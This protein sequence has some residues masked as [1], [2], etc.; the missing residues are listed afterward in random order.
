MCY[1]KNIWRVLWYHLCCI[2]PGQT[3]EGLHIPWGAKNKAGQLLPFCNSRQNEHEDGKKEGKALRQACLKK[4]GYLLLPYGNE[5]NPQI[6]WDCPTVF[7]YSVSSY[8]WEITLTQCQC[9]SGRKG[10]K[11]IIARLNFLIF[12]VFQYQGVAFQSVAEWKL[13]KKTLLCVA[14]GRG[15][16]KYLVKLLNVVLDELDKPRMNRW[17]QHA[18]Y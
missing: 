15:L 17:E 10:T 12:V 14:S 6:V 18:N 8:T 9:G 2:F 3:W 5:G 4:N 13:L 11:G 1:H 16:S 7:F